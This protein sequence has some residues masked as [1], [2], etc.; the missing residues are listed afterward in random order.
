MLPHFMRRMTQFRLVLLATIGLATMSIRGATNDAPDFA[1]VQ[2]LLRGH[3]SGA[4]ETELNRL[5]VEGLLQVLHG[6]VTLVGNDVT[7]AP[8]NFVALARSSLWK[9][10]S[11]T[12]G[13]RVSIK[14]LQPRFRR[15]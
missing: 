7:R 2:S 5:A 1:E 13:L 15:R 11:P 4:T 3:L 12:C 14:A 6:K 10:T 8:S 9:A